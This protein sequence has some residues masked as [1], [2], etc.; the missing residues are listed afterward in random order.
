MPSGQIYVSDRTQS[1]LPSPLPS[2]LCYVDHDLMQTVALHN[3]PPHPAVEFPVCNTHWSAPILGS[4]IANT[5][6][7]TPDASISAFLPL[8]PCKHW[9]HYR[10]FIAR[11][12]DPWNPY[13]NKFPVCNMQIYHWDGITV[14]TIATRTGF[15]LVDTNPHV[16][17]ITAHQLDYSFLPSADT[18]EYLS[19][20]IIVENLIRHVFFAYLGIR[21][22]YADGSPDR[23]LPKSKWL[24]RSTQMGALLFGMLVVIKMTRFLVEGQGGILRT[25]AWRVFKDGGRYK[26]WRSEVICNQ[27]Y[28]GRAIGLAWNR[29]VKRV[30][31]ILI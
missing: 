5:A 22:K 6:L 2:L 29:C 11:A 9:L 21:C 17:C 16:H 20:C 7:W 19:E 8:S 23:Q 15:T 1:S 14:L 18:A 25:E 3:R 10:C 13:K 26:S 4:K 27:G 28:C 30:L 12:Y 24:R 31:F